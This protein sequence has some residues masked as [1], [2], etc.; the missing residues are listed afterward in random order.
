MKKKNNNNL[1][2][3]MLNER[4]T[5]EE[6]EGKKS[7]TCECCMQSLPA[8][9]KE[10]Q[11]DIGVKERNE[12]HSRS[13]L[14]IIIG[15]SLTIPLVLL[16]IFYDSAITHYILLALATP[17]QFILGKPFY[18]RFFRALRL[19]HGFTTD[20]LV[21]LSTSVAYSYSLFSLLA[22]SATATIFFEASA[23]VLTIFTIGEYLEGRVIRTTS[24]SIKNLLALRPKTAV[25]IR[26]RND[27]KGK[28][29]E[30]IVVDADS[31]VIGDI[32]VAKPGDKIAADGVVVY[33]ESSVDESMITGESIPVDKKIGD[34]VIG[35]TINKNGY[36]RFRA[37]A[38]GSHTILASIIEM[39]ERARV[40]KA[41]IQRIAGK[42]VR[43][44][45]PIV[46]FIAAASS[47]YW[48]FIAEQS[49]AFA[50][51]IFATV[52]VVSCP[53]A[54][55]IATPMVVSL[56][57]DKAA[58]EGVLIKGG[59]YLEKLANIDTVIFDKTGTL[60]KGKPEVTDV[61]S[62]NNGYNQYDILQIASSLEN[63]SEHPI[64]QAIINKAS[65]Q[66]IPTLEVS[67]FNSIS[68]HG[69][70]AFYQ[71]KRIFVGS[72]TTSIATTLNNGSSI[73][74]QRLQS[75]ISKLE[76]EGKTVVAVYIEDKLVGLIAVADTLR[77]DAKHTIDEIKQMNKEVILISGDNERTANAI[78]NKLGINNVLA[79]VMPETKAQEVKKLQD[80]GKK[81]AMIGD[82]INDAPALTQADVGIAMSSGTDV[83]MSSGHVILMKSDLYHV[84]SAFKIGQ[85]SF[86]KIKQNLAMSFAYNAITISIA[87]GL[88]YGVTHSVI[89]T[90]A[91][92]ALGWII[93]DSAVFGNSLLVR[94]FIPNNFK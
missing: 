69:I 65:K 84:L 13:K 89:L 38:V 5:E 58:R 6:E 67:Q 60:T 94:K 62:N 41:P 87:A 73:I 7:I 14:L 12:D 63:R 2:N 88:L 79:Q 25:V 83:A 59:E 11:G 86:K 50:I 1:S 30:E 29:E 55:G 64:A 70:M 4:E 27:K 75:E 46:L 44:F 20:T 3:K 48:L 31:I 77:E 76:A 45:I 28:E 90:P 52:L 66:S 85:Y 17:V 56:G 19:R 71:E 53:C 47:I 15:L 21:V 16:E 33:G 9:A 37:T 57:I 68:G 34:K 42:A 36:I 61:I 74:P 51:T 80:Q 35:A 22:D 82:G 18:L 93:S 78:A 91:L 92:A 54:L 40:S 81:V 26:T 23:S 49:I 43:Y 24:E 72:P 8:Q 10:H 39:V 32:V